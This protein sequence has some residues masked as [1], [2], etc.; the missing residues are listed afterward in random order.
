MS[1]RLFGRLD[2]I[3]FSLFG[4]V[5]AK[6]FSGGRYFHMEARV[7]PALPLPPF[8]LRY[9]PN[10]VMMLSLLHSWENMVIFLQTYLHFSRHVIKFCLLGIAY[11]KKVVLSTIFFKCV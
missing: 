11:L 3:W 6:I 10:C 5:M 7:S 9:C 1:G 8:P 2:L 4:M